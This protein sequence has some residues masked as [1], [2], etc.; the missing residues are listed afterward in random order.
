MAYPI[1]WRLTAEEIGRIV[2]RAAPRLLLV[3][4]STLPLVA[5]WP[6]TRAA[7]AS[8][9]TLGSTE[10]PGFTPSRR[11]I[12]LLGSWGPVWWHQMT[13]LRLSPLPQ[14]ISCRVGRC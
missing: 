7:I 12:T 11:C 8:W 9:Y 5:D 2:E 1:N 4:D 14:W 13:R 6:R 3:D 10:A